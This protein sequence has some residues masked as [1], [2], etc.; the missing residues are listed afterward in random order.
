MIISAGRIVLGVANTIVGLVIL[1]LG[2]DQCQDARTL[3][4]LSAGVIILHIT[5]PFLGLGALLLLWNKLG[6]QSLFRTVMTAITTSIVLLFVLAW[7]L[8]L[9]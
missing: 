7:L 1:A 3:I 4:E 2:L 5:L 6:E 8:W 9:T